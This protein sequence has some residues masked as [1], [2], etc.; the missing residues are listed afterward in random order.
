[1]VHAGDDRRLGGEVAGVEPAPGRGV[2]GGE[3]CEAPGR[4]L[5]V[6]ADRQRAAIGEDLRPIRVGREQLEAMVREAQ[7]LRRRRQLGHQIA[8]GMHVRKEAR[9]RKRL[10]D[11]HAADRG[12]ALQ[13]EH[14]EPGPG[15][16]AGAGEAVVAGADDRR[17]VSDHACPLRKADRREQPWASLG[18]LQA[19]GTGAATGRQRQR[20]RHQ[21]INFSLS[22]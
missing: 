15:E 12:V 13:H 22:P 6:A 10:G 14:L 7:L 3:L 21:P 17:V 4:R 16:I 1:M 20:C 8:A 2:A 11:R 18:P 9:C 5:D 19:A